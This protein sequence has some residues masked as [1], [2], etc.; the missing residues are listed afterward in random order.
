MLIP[1]GDRILIKQKVEAENLS[2]SGIIVSAKEEKKLP[3]GEV[4]AVG[5]KVQEIKVGDIV[6]FEGW[7]GEPVNEEIGGEKDLMLLKVDRVIAKYE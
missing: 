2:K 1:F 5:A 6:V 3:M 7:N 4:K